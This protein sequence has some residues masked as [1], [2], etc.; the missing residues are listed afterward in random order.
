MWT[1]ANADTVQR[2]QE[3]LATLAL[4]LG[5]LLID[6]RGEEGITHTDALCPPYTDVDMRQC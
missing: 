2:T 3:F 1:C 5:V 4:V 6:A